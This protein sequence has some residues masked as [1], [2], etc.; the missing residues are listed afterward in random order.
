MLVGEL[1][2]NAKIWV[3]DMSQK[4]LTRHLSDN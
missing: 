1:K 2:K 3:E 4:S